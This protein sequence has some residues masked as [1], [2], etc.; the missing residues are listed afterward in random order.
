[1]TPVIA[2]EVPTLALANCLTASSSP[3]SSLLKFLLANCNTGVLSNVKFK[4]LT[5]V[6]K[7]GTNILNKPF[8]SKPS[9]TNLAKP[10]ICLSLPVLGSL[11]ILSGRSLV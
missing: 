9:C 4:M 11:V 2:K 7:K 8:L 5:G 3:V 1:M 10:L 6:L